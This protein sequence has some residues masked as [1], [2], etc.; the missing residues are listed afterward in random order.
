[1]S[2]LTLPRILIK[3]A[4]DLASG[5]SLRLHRCGFPVL[6]TELARP[7]AVRRTVAFAQAVYDGECRVE[8]VTA[9]RAAPGDV[10]ALLAAG[11]IPVLVEPPADIAARVG[12]GVVVDAILAKRN[13]GTQRSDAPLVI[14]LGPGFSAGVDGAAD[15]HAVIETQRGH[16]L[17]RVIWRG[18]AIADTGI[19]GDLPGAAPAGTSRVLRAPATGRLEWLVQIGDHVEPGQS[20]GWFI[21]EEGSRSAI[22]APFAGVVRGLIHPS[23]PMAPRLKI[24]DVDARAQRDACFTV[25]DKSL[26]IGGG[27]LEAI[28]TAMA[29]ELLPPAAP[30]IPR[31]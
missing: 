31:A 16:T 14:A 7:L 28:L 10:D 9:R 6:H 23:V 13:L 17:G 11:E 26:A 12:A 29:R 18:A 25:S 5:V 19:P 30:L 21:D 2:A 3:G 4:G 15:C 8:E 27:V 20:L 22:P 24:G 1:M